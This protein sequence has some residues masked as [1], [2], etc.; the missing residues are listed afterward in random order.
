M[1]IIV[2]NG[3]PRVGKDTF[4]ELCDK[5]LLWCKNYST[6]DFVK[7]IAVKCG[8]DGSKTPKNR[9]FLSDLKDLLARWK[10]VPFKKI[11]ERIRAFRKSIEGLGYDNDEVGIVFIHSREPEE[12]KRFVDKFNATSLLIRR[13]SVES[14]EQSNHADSQVMD[15]EYDYVIENNGTK[16]ELEQKAVEFLRALELPKIAFYG[17]M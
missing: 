3:Q 14:T 17:K 4:V 8:W 11:E 16:E 12:I 2:I 13:E 7:E 9:A 10:D 1:K 15:Y 5:H 6:V